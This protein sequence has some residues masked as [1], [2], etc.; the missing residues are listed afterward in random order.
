MEGRELPSFLVWHV[1]WG[2]QRTSAIDSYDFEVVT[3]FIYLG[4]LISCKNDLEEEI[5]RRIIT[6]NRRYYGMLKLEKSQLL[7]G[8][9]KCQ[10][11]NSLNEDKN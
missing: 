8:K 4:S 11:S 2:L 7:K 3:E 6:G 10:L 1:S 9:S 5:K